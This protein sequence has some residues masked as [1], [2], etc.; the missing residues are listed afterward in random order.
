MPTQKPGLNLIAEPGRR[1]AALDMA[2]DIERRGFAEIQVS[3][4]YA[5]MA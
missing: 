5:N 3:S 1:G 2:R 4:S